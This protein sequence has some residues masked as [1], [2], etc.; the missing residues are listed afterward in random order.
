MKKFYPTDAGKVCFVLIFS[1]LCT[2]FAHAQIVT[3]DTTFD[4]WNAIVT[5]DLSLRGTDSA[6]G[7]I[8]F[9]G[10]GQQTKNIKDLQ[11]NGPHYLI[12][13]G[14]WDG[15][16]T[17][18]NGVHHPFIISLQPPAS[19]YPATV[20]KP[21][22]DAIMA[23]YRIRRNSLYFTALSQGAWQ[24][25]EFLAYQATSGDH[26][27]GR[28]VKA[29]VNLE[30]VEPADYTGVYSSL[31]YP[32]KMGDWAKA[33]GGRELWVEGSQDWRDM[34]AGAQNMNDAVP[35]SATYFQVTYGGGAHCCWNTEYEPNV[36]WT[37]AS[38]PNI[39]QVVGTAVPMNV[40]QWM[41]RQGDTSMPGGAPAPPAAGPAA[42]AG[43]A[44]TIT[45]P[46]NT[47][48]LTGSGTGNNGAKVSSMSW[49]QTSGPN[50]ADIK[51]GNLV[52]AVLNTAANV[53][54]AA[55]GATMNLSA[56]VSGMITGNYTFQLTVKDNKGVASTSSV[57]VNVNAAPP[58][59]PSAPNVSAGSDP[60]ITLPVTTTTLNGTAA[61][62]NG[63]KITAILWQETQGPV[64]ARIASPSSLS[65]SISGL[66]AAGTYIFRMTV[67]DKNG[68]QAAST[69]D[70]VVKPA[71]TVTTKVPPTV[72]A[73]ANQTITLP[74]NS[75]TLTGK[76]AGNGG[77]VVN[78]YFWILVSGP[79]EVKFSNE[80]A[81][82]T[83][84]GGLV[85]GTYA[86]KLSASD[87]YDQTS[88]SML[89]V[90]VNAAKP[91]PPKPATPPA[92]PTT[93]NGGSAGTLPTVSAG[94]GQQITLPTSSTK[95]Q[96][97]AAG[98][99]GAKIV[100]VSWVQE[101][102]PEKVKIASPAS[103]NTTVT[104]MTEPGAYIFKLIVIDNNGKSSN[105][106]MTVTV[107]PQVAKV[108]PT[109][110]AGANQTVTLPTSSA[111]LKGSATGHNGAVVNG[112]FWVFVS[113]PSWV[114]FGSEWASTTTVSGL[115]AGTYVFELSASDNNDETSTSTMEL[116]VKPKPAVA[117]ASTTGG[118][119]GGT[120]ETSDAAAVT[121]PATLDSIDR[122]GGLVIFPNPVH[123]L[124]NLRLADKTTGKLLIRIIDENGRLVQA[125]TLEK[126]G[127]SVETSVDVAKLNKG[128]YVIQLMT[129]SG[130]ITTRRFVKL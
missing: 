122:A 47:V 98:T 31:T 117:G 82:S 8:F 73:G 55:T 23:R 46:T 120:A 66:T 15:S 80:W 58:P 118:S 95:L 130:G 78:S 56:T 63:A 21:K 18:G 101:S 41:L 104:G 7:I 62:S 88:T 38:N 6:A 27:Y 107:D 32:N 16:V 77:A 14:M 12:N 111:T 53:V 45:L 3:K 4:G 71:A 70:V 69:V 93:G 26:T 114:K 91:A 86:F 48:N 42:N 100:T 49:A 99:N 96:G 29:M 81:L 9:P 64:T 24:A 75:V 67:T 65:T 129:A 128:V 76:V 10:I 92:P 102:G 36:T 119:A 54:D 105:G 87:N 37:K 83:T 121:D 109:V 61:G 113:G 103:L 90:T 116:V 74:A 11:V 35:G 30:G 50:N 72:N 94:K 110:S 5:E 39:S 123:E 40:W 112:Y 22:I 19:G 124:L 2:R 126:N 59:P 34:L 89:T 33:C 13:N 17:L 115:V 60:T 51:A 108:P 68:K 1:C 57:T 43:V 52:S 125:S 44:Q 97:T 127:T 28:M 106:S 84:V 25:N 20:V 79:S 85:V